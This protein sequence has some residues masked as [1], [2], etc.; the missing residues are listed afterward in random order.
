M[1]LLYPNEQF[2]QWRS[3]K[4]KMNFITAVESERSVSH[5]VGYTDYRLVKTPDEW[6][7]WILQFRI[8]TPCSG[9][10]W[11]NYNVQRIRSSESASGFRL[12]THMGHPSR[13]LSEVPLHRVCERCTNWARNHKRYLLH[14]M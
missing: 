8:Q 9:R 3:A 1:I 7:F 14:L 11:H 4:M 12:L 13:Q 10:R 6:P 2:G 5:L